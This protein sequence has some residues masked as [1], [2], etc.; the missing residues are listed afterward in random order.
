MSLKKNK[1]IPD[2][3]KKAISKFNDIMSNRSN[4]LEG[5]N[6]AYKGEL[7]VL[8]FLS[9]REV[10]AIPSEL[11]AALHSSTARI[12]ALLGSLEKKGQIERDIDRKNRRNILVTITEAGRTRARKERIELEK[13]LAHVFEEMGEED[14]AEYLRLSEEFFGIMQ[15][16]KSDERRY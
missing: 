5:M 10:A 1:N 6:R 13:I 12:S 16:Y 4:T 14:V 9:M 8:Q 15:K 2:Y 11:S 7:F 3:V